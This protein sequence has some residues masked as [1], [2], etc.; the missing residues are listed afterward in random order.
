MWLTSDKELLVVHGGDSGEINFGAQKSEA[1]VKQYVFL[2]TLAEN[3]L[4]NTVHV[5]PTLRQVFEL[6]SKLCFIN[7]EIKVPYDKSVRQKYERKEV[8]VAVHALIRE[9][10][11]Q[12][13]CFVSSFCPIAMR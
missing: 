9:F 6:V 13:H 1:D 10:E 2:S 4:L 5:M 7:L 8:V 3:R 12:D 11:L